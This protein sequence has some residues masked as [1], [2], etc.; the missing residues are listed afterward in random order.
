MIFSLIVYS[1]SGHSPS[2]TESSAAPPPGG[3]TA[4]HFA[5]TLLAH[6]HSLY[7]VFFYGDG[8][9]Q[10]FL[11]D[12]NAPGAAAYSAPGTHAAPHGHTGKQWSDLSKQHQ[13]DLVVCVS[14]ALKR[15]LISEEEGQ[16]PEQ[17]CLRLLP[18]FQISGLGQLTDAAI[19]SDRTITFR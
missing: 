19:H 10:A 13:L 5:K 14:A 6:G 9:H 18:G 15:G 11:P 17:A 4:L 2:G 8:V 1:S 7:R 3:Q 16:H 12:S